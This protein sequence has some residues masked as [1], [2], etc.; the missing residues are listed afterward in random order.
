MKQYLIIGQISLR[1]SNSIDL[2]LN[3]AKKYQQAPK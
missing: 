3:F 1:Y 2:Q